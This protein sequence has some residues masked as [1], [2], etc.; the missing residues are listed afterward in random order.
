MDVEPTVLSE[1]GDGRDDLVSTNDVND[2]EN[3]QTWPTEDEIK[4][5][6][7]EIG[8]DADHLPDAKEGTTPKVIRKVPKGTS[9]YQ[10]AW[11]LDSEDEDS[12]EDQDEDIHSEQASQDDDEKMDDGGI[13]NDTGSA[14]K[15]KSRLG[16]EY[17]DL[18]EEQTS[19]TVAFEDMDM[20]EERKQ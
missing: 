8:T 2:M 7:S 6:G 15:E 10:A 4:T 5:A 17:E 13:D 1:P 11:L 20:E 16:E 9:A 19:K 18:L 3:E 12:S 14:L